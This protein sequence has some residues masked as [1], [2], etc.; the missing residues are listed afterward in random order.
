MKKMWATPNPYFCLITNIFCVVVTDV[1]KACCYSL[2]NRNK[3]KNLGIGVFENLLTGD[4]LNN[5]D[6]N[7]SPYYVSRN[8]S[9]WYSFQEGAKMLFC[10]R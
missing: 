6:S 1:C 8:L 10:W 9:F 5:L 4:L 2:S 3:E 7:L